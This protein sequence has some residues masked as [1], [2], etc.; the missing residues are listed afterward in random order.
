MESKIKCKVIVLPCESSKI[1]KR[2]TDGKMWA[3]QH[4]TYKETDEI[5]PIELY[6][7]SDEEITLSS[8]NKDVFIRK[9]SMINSYDV[10]TNPMFTSKYK[11]QKVLASSDWT[12]GIE[13]IPFSFINKFIESNGTI[14]E[15]MIEMCNNDFI[16]NNEIKV[17]YSPK[18][19]HDGTVII[20]K[21][22]DT[23]NC[24]EHYTDMQYYM[25]YCQSN[26]YVTP[27]K[28]LAE[29]KHY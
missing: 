26:G 22:K 10:I 23:W 2:K 9:H 18:T 27:Q 25:E 21:I 19:R 15:V 8:S 17:I 7:V 1:Y 12:L 5:I 20:S 11:Y 14:K 13:T 3:S 28:W 6:L 24:D 29:F 4:T 16:I